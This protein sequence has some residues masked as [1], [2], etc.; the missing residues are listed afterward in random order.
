MTISWHILTVEFTQENWTE[1]SSLGYRAYLR[2]AMNKLRPLGVTIRQPVLHLCSYD[3]Q[4]VI[5]MSATQIR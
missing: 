1:L 5:G 4:S 3:A 2:G